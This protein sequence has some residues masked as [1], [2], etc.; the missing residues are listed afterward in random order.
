MSDSQPQLQSLQSP[1]HDQGALGRFAHAVTAD[2]LGSPPRAPELHLGYNTLPDPPYPMPSRLRHGADTVGGWLACDQDLRSFLES[3]ARSLRGQPVP[4][5]ESF[6]TQ[7]RMMQYLMRIDSMALAWKART[8]DPTENVGAWTLAAD[9]LAGRAVPG[10]ITP[11][12][13]GEAILAWV[14]DRSGRVLL[15]AAPV[16]GTED[17]ITVAEAVPGAPDEIAGLVRDILDAQYA[18]TLAAFGAEPPPERA[19][20]A[21]ALRNLKPA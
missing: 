8:V 9:L 3:G 12:V 17:D 15:A 18:W 19:D 10:D 1:D 5:R 4:P 2:Y 13:S 20:L 21:R 11:D 16:G 14:V 7:T 6:D